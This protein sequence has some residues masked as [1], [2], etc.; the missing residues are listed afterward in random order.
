MKPTKYTKWLKKKYVIFGVVPEIT[1]VD[2]IVL[3]NGQRAYGIF[4]HEGY[5][6]QISKAQLEETKIKTLIHELNHALFERT[7]LNQTDI[8][9][10]LQ[11]V[12]CETFSTYIFEN[13]IKK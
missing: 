5:K 2:E 3:E 8:P 12:I 9:L 6:I 1:M 11:E 4:F 7:G 13:F 10:N